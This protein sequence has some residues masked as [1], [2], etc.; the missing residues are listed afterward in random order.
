[1]NFSPLEHRLQE[2]LPSGKLVNHPTPE[3]DLSGVLEEVADQVAETAE[4]RESLDDERFWW[5]IDGKIIDSSGLM[6]LEWD[7]PPRVR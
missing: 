2:L 6:T 1:L 7:G 4:E 5:L 3:I